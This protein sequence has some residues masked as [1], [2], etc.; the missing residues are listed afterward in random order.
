[1]GYGPDDM[2]IARKH[3]ALFS[4]QMKDNNFF[5][6]E[7]KN[8]L[9]ADLYGTSITQVGWKR[10]EPMRIIEMI[11]RAPVSGQMIRSVRKGKVIM[12][13]GPETEGVDRLDFF[14]QTGVGD[15]DK[16]GH[17][18]RRSYVDL[19][20]LRAMA[21]QGIFDEHEVER[22]VK[23][24]GAGAQYAD[25][26]KGHK[27]FQVR[28]GMDEDSSRH[29][30]RYTRPVEI[31]EMWGEIP[32]ELAPDGVTN[33][34][35][36]IANRRYLL[37][38]R[39]NP[40][41]HDKKPFQIY[42][43]TPD[44]HYFDAPGKAEVS[45]K[46]QIVA[47]RFMNQ[48]LDAADLIIDPMWFYDRAANLKTNGLFAKPGLFVPVDG[49][50]NKVVSPMT[51][52]LDSMLVGDQKMGQ[53]QQFVQMATGLYD[54]VVKG[55]PSSGGRQ[56]AREVMARREA[57]GTRLMLESRLYEEMY[58]ERL[59]NMVMANNK[60]FLQPPVEINIL[61]DAS[62]M[63]PVTGEQ[64]SASREL[65]TPYDMMYTYAARATGATTALSKGMQQQ[66]LIALLGAMAQMP[67]VFGAI[68]AVNF[69]RNMFRAF[70]VPN[71]NELFQQS[72]NPL[73]QLVTQATGGQGDINAVPSSGQI[74]NAPQEIAQ[75][76]DGEGPTGIQGSMIPAGIAG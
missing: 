67:Q 52:N 37:R 73:Q 35:I 39:P 31:L 69:W 59:G 55:G 14:P 53:M 58:L 26:D 65:M 54:D 8:I 43:P 6:K 41:W 28:T 42:S 63:D 71:I 16:M 51:S 20:D 9:Q 22:I 61:G 50:P 57:A 30:D 18:T 68:N 33:R 64:I 46:L 76:G 72:G 7:V 24:G 75:M 36:T 32:S 62:Q 3:E 23:E 66:N 38:N 74:R 25:L 29:M 45:E 48:T 19:D 2:S 13:D 56:T 60:Q 17:A 12:F 47:N 70:E 44:P 27:R 5:L 4:A 1:M 10:E 40:F 15:F 11:T 21:K 34:V 49:D